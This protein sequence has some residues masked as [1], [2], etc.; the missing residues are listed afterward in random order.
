VHNL[1]HCSKYDLL[2][3]DRKGAWLMVRGTRRGVCV[4]VHV[5]VCVCV[6][7]SS[8]ALMV[9]MVGMLYISSTPGLTNSH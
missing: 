9:G 4:C 8:I 2:N 6:C 7:V 3:I 1:P 5:H